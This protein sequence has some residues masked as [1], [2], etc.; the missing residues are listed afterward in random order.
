MTKILNIL[1][2]VKAK[3]ALVVFILRSGG[4]LLAESGEVLTAIAVA[5]ETG[6]I[7]KAKISAIMVEAKDVIALVK[8][9]KTELD[10]VR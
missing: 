3:L 2:A 9:F 10:A 8:L 7:D 6:K 4:E 5:V 1:K